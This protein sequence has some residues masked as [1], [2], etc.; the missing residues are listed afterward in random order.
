MPV[1][2]VDTVLLVDGSNLFFRSF[3][4]IKY[5]Q[6]KT[7]H[8]LR[9]G[10][11]EAH[12]FMNTYLSSLVRFTPC[13]S[14]ILWDFGK[15]L[16]RQSLY[17][18]YKGK[19]AERDPADEKRMAYLRGI[20][21][22]LFPKLGLLSIGVQGIEADDLICYFY[23]ALRK[24]FNVA[25]LS[26]DADLQQFPNTIVC[27]AN[28]NT[29][30]V[31]KE[32]AKRLVLNK[33][34]CGDKS[35]NVGNGVV[36]IGPKKFEA[37]IDDIGLSYTA[38]LGRYS[39][40][41]DTVEAIERNRHLLDLCFVNDRVVH[42][43]ARSCIMKLLARQCKAQRFS[44]LDASMVMSRLGLSSLAANISGGTGKLLEV[45]HER[46]NDMC[47]CALLQRKR[48]RRSAITL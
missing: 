32:S 26:N 21:A 19:R 35:D 23:R 24:N 37:L 8:S 40:S 42:E 46:T 38:L 22:D 29:H 13:A 4:A 47:R 28:L 43:A 31:D 6:Q 45:T 3:Y 14:I 2:L 30:F 20:M 36:G 17:P 27:D 9:R 1:K 25:I 34:V 11:L 15:S 41:L 18:E 39:E 12:V 10:I 33:I 44:K 16:Y 7:D 5:G 48:V